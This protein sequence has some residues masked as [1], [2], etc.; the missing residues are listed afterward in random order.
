MSAIRWSIG[1]LAIMSVRTG[2]RNK[3][4]EP[5]GPLPIGSA[6]VDKLQK[7]RYVALRIRRVSEWRKRIIDPVDRA[8]S[9]ES[10]D[11]ACIAFPTAGQ[12]LHGDALAG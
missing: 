7:R 5:R 4:S 6:S 11:H 2:L 8:P 9:E 1:V 12:N 3:K 10:L